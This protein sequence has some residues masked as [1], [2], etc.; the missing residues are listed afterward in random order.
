MDE[1]S[2]MYQRNT[3]KISQFEEKYTR[4]QTVVDNCKNLVVHF[5]KELL[6][7]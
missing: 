7:T 2:Q 4:Q 5:E 6:E 3:A 1:M